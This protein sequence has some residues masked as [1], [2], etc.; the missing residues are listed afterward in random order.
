M[1]TRQ[2]RRLRLAAEEKGKRAEKEAF[3]ALVRKVKSNCAKDKAGILAVEYQLEYTKSRKIAAPKLSHD[4]TVEAY[5]K[6]IN[7]Y[8]E[9]EKKKQEI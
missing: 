2:D 8:K 1:E 5:N 4:R 9:N 7:Q 3:N 6:G